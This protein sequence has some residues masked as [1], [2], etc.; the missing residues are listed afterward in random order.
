MEAHYLVNLESFFPA[1]NHCVN[2]VGQ[3]FMLLWNATFFQISIFLKGGWEIQ[4]YIGTSV[5]KHKVY[6]VSLK[7]LKQQKKLKNRYR[8]TIPCP[9]G[10]GTRLYFDKHCSRLSAFCIFNTSINQIQMWCNP[11][12]FYS[13][14]QSTKAVLL[15]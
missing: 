5:E 13:Y 4:I 8:V 12:Q 7:K 6:K 1:M 15:I 3:H 11:M 14:F 9:S 2:K 10:R